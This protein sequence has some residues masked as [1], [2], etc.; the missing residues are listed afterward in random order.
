M[1][2]ILWCCLISWIFWPGFTWAQTTVPNAVTLIVRITETGTGKPVSFVSGYLKRG[3]N[4]NTADENGLLPLSIKQL[5]D[6][7]LLSEVGYEPVTVP[8]AAQPTEPLLINMR[9][10]TGQL[11]EVVVTGYR[12]PG[13]ALMKK[14]IANKRTNDPQRLTRWTRNNYLRTEVD[15]ENLSANQ[16]RKLLTTMLKVY[17]QFQNDSSARTS[18]P[19]FFRE[20]YR[21]EYH[22]RSPQS[23]AAYLV[24][25]QNLG[26]QTDE[27]GQR[28]DRFNEPVNPYDGIIPIQKTSFVG[29]VSDIG[30]AVYQF[31]K[32][33]T[34][35]DAGKYSYRLTFRPRSATENGFVGSVLI[36]DGSYAIREVNIRTNAGAN[37]NFI[38]SLSIQQTYLPIDDSERG[39]VWVLTKNA[40]RYGFENGLGLL[41]LPTRIDSTSRT[42]TIQ[43]TSVYGNYRVNPEGVTATNFALAEQTTPSAATFTD[44]Y[45]LSPLTI[46]ERAIYQAVDSLKNNRQ[47]RNTT[48]MAAF[49]TT[50][51]WD[52]RNKIRLGPYSS[53]FSSNL[54]EGLRIRTGIWTME[55]FDPR[56]CL[57]GYVAYGTRD[58]RFKETVGIKYVPNRSP[59][60]KYELTLKNDYDALT[61]NDDMLDNDN[62]FTLALRKPIPVYQ[63]FLRQVRFAHERDL[64][65]LWSVKTYYSYGSMTP[66]FKFSYAPSD[67][68]VNVADSS[69]SLLNTLYNSEAGVT[70]RYARNERTALVNYDKL[71]LYTRFPV[72]QFHAA[73][74]V[75]LYRNTYFDYWRLSTSLT[76]EMPAPLKGSFYYN[77]TG[78]VVLGTVPL[79]LLHIPRGNP[80][81]VADKY[82]F[83]GMSPY[84]FAADRYIS[85]LTRYSLGGLILD[86]IPLLN[87]L[88]LR[89]R[90]TANLFWGSLSGANRD[91][92]KINTFRTTGSVPYAEAGVGIENILNLF[93]ID[94]IW[95]LNYLDGADAARSTRFGIYTGLKLQ[96]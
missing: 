28:L 10:V 40:L 54:T 53:L 39:T 75:P 3:R 14:V 31:D 52:V 25:E 69:V 45:R 57:W 38:R 64:S 82:A 47:F 77:L 12:D 56:W 91:F 85:L 26:L 51:Y 18:L 43:S 35:I 1:K 27:I 22:I 74:G 87:K 15:I 58:R 72:W 32:P 6:T 37:L 67:E 59:Y 65:P 30:L 50:G 36:E 48:R 93:S 42:V 17:Q 70:F 7:L 79:L 4:G 63:N 92:N 9:T 84:E 83:Y 90:V 24:S 60:Q 13:K 19:I 81:Y 20:Q 16:K 96:F 73:A 61:A 2:N 41:G 80:N 23:D 33:D 46:R 49:I 66:T 8:I 71:R 34:L 29:P 44:A 89:E 86:R 76:Q 11:D 68:T 55:G 21:K 88:G 94:A 62:L 5:P 78:G 95:R